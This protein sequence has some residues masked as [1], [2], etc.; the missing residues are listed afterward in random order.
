VLRVALIALSVSALAPTSSWAAASAWKLVS[1]RGEV[2]L[3]VEDRRPPI[4]CTDEPTS[5]VASGDYRAEL[6]SR[7]AIFGRGYGVYNGSF[8]SVI[9]GFHVDL[10]LRLEGTERVKTATAVYD[11]ETDTEQCQIEERSCSGTSLRRSRAAGISFG[12]RRRGRRLGP[13]LVHFNG[14]WFFHSCDRR[15]SDPIDHLEAR[16]GPQGSEQLP[17]PRA[18]LPLSRFRPRRMRITM[19]GTAPLREPFRGGDLDARLSWRLVW[20]LRRTVVAHEGCLEVGRRSGFVCEVV[21]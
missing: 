2:R 9:G 4:H 19:K 8:G 18:I 10:K 12:P 5:W 20:T 11:P 13:V 21:G 14:A 1:V 16:R 6:S 17:E 15:A 7:R 3:A